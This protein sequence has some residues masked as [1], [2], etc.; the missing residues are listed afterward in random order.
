M[1]PK[2]IQRFHEINQPLD[3]MTLESLFVSQ[4]VPIFMLKGILASEGFLLQLVDGFG[5]KASGL[6][7]LGSSF[8]RK[9]SLLPLLT[10]EARKFVGLGFNY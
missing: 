4:G 6:S 2:Y 7:G 1:D 5:F 8:L 10:L 3:D 9:M